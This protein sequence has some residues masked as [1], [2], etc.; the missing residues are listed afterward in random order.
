MVK[1]YF[2]NW[3]SIDR[4]VSTQ[5]PF[6]C[7]V[8]LQRP[9]TNVKKISLKSLELPISFYSLRSPYNTF[10]IR[11]T[12]PTPTSTST[13]TLSE[14][15]YTISTLCAELASQI[16]TLFGV[17]TF[18]VTYSTLTNKITISASSGATF[19]FIPA[20]CTF[21]NKILGFYG[22]NNVY[23]NTSVTG[24]LPYLIN[25]DNYICLKLSYLPSNYVNSD[26][27]IH[28]KIPLDETNGVVYIQFEGSAYSQ[29]I[30]ISNPHFSLNEIK[31]EVFDR[32]NYALTNNFTDFSM[33]LQI[34]CDE[35]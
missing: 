33:T 20:S 16:N 30:E 18:T 34:D 27:M 26:Q 19:G 6:A 11:K 35:D 8:K 3:D 22:V 24:T 1:T 32:Y 13:I 5:D 14:G 25:W 4:T 28:Y 9:L 31:L 15:N 21:L 23:T 10:H 12:T 17:T 7:S 2:F 29:F